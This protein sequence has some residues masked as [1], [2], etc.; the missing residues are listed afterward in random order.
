VSLGEVLGSH[1]PTPADPDYDRAEVVRSERDHP[2]GNAR[3]PVE[4]CGQH[5]QRGSDDRGRREPEQRVDAARIAAGDD[6]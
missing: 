2:H 6:P 4:E 3:V 1:T 5:E